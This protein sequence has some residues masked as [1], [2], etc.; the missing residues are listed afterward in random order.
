MIGYLKRSSQEKGKAKVIIGKEA[1][2]TRMSKSHFCDLDNVHSFAH[3]Q[4]R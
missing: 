1:A 3:V 4:I 2:V